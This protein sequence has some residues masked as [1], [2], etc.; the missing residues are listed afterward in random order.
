MI[1]YRTVSGVYGGVTENNIVTTIMIVELLSLLLLLTT[2]SASEG[3]VVSVQVY[4]LSEPYA[5]SEATIGTI[6][7]TTSKEVQQLQ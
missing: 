7:F 4:F 3:I 5:T 1:N 2:L 6:P